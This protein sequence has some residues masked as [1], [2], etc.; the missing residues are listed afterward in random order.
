MRIKIIAKKTIQTKHK[1][2]IIKISIA[3][4]CCLAHVNSYRLNQFHSNST[5]KDNDFIIIK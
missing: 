3:V 5:L 4:M 2:Y 1:N